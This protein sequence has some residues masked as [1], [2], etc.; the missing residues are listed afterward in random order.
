M[1]REYVYA[2]C[3]V[4]SL[5]VA[6]RSRDTTLLI[7]KCCKVVSHIAVVPHVY[8]VK[9]KWMGWSYCAKRRDKLTNRKVIKT[10]SFCW[11]ICSF[12][13]DTRQRMWNK[14]K[15]RRS[16]FFSEN[17]SFLLLLLFHFDCNKLLTLCHLGFVCVRFA[18][19][20]CC[21]FSGS[22]SRF[23]EGLWCVTGYVNSCCI[24]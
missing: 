18:W 19:R 4:C 9:I 11:L 16:K 21:W 24:T 8:N 20:M 1:V 17:F 10:H 7:L 13:S 5:D 6:Y 23:F 3:S 2:L 12:C 15:Q 22:S 14:S